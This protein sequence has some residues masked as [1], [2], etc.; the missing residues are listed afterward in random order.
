MS[1]ELHVT[2]LVVQ[3]KPEFMSSVRQTIMKMENAE[4]SVNDEVKL[5]VVLEGMTQKGLMADIETI[6]KIEGVL[7]AAM[8]YHQSEVLEEVEK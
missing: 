3:V 5:V 6:N 1:N 2:S 8:V 7:S 4:L